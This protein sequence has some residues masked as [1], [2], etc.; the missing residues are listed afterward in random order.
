[1]K[2]GAASV[3]TNDVLSA[4]TRALLVGLGMLVAE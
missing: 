1:M 4:Q 3:F 2:A